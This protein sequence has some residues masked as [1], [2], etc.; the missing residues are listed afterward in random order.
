M[1]F[2]PE[3]KENQRYEGHFDFDQVGE[4]MWMRYRLP[5]D[6]FQPMGM[7]QTKKLQDFMVDAKIPRICRDSIPLLV[8]PKGILWVVGWRVSEWAKISADTRREIQ[9]RFKQAD[10]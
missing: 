1:K 3:I 5:G 4:R 8:S 2:G 10:I 9:I 6:R 7:K